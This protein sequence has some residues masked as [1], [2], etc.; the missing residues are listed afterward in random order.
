MS[1]HCK[2]LSNIN[3]EV[4]QFIYAIYQEHLQNNKKEGMKYQL[5][6][7]TFSFLAH[8][9]GTHRCSNFFLYLSLPIHYPRFKHAQ[10]DNYSAYFCIFFYIC[11]LI[12]ALSFL[13]SLVNRLLDLS[14]K[15]FH[16]IHY[17]RSNPAAER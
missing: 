14:P 6:T 15:T 8:N 5:I 13:H 10:Y 9:L 12:L 16:T 2:K 4:G 1:L 3:L 17:T 7:N 11:L